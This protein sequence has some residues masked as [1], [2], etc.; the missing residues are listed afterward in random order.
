[1]VAEGNELNLA[2]GDAIEDDNREVAGFADL[3]QKPA[4][5]ASLAARTGLSGWCGKAIF[6]R[7]AA[8][9]V[10]AH[11]FGGLT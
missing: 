7:R 10:P 8:C 9:S 6:R 3:P 11:G 5:D 4:V 2:S 1:L